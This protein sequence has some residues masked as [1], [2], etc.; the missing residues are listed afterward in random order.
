M[1]HAVPD[2]LLTGD[3]DEAG[4]VPGLFQG[5]HDVLRGR[6][7]KTSKSSGYLNV[8][9]RGSPTLWGSDPH[10]LTHPQNL[11]LAAGTG[12]GEVLPVA[13]L[14]VQLALLLHEPI[15][16]QG[17]VAVG[18]GEFLRVP[19]QTHGYEEGT[20]GGRGWRKQLPLH[21]FSLSLGTSRM[22][23]CQAQKQVCG[24]I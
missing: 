24:Q 10:P 7:I 19:R 5:I 4:H 12:G 6:Q 1:K 9:P 22:G 8:Q 14:T 18:T 3:A 23:L 13:M 16:H 11:V 20:S 15:F 17:G 2:G 21:F